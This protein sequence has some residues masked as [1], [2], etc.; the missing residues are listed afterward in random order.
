MLSSNIATLAYVETRNTEL[1][2]EASQSRLARR[3]QGRTV[4]P[5]F[6]RSAR[7]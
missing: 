7:G 4:R 1:R 3:V 6:T 2:R 5:A